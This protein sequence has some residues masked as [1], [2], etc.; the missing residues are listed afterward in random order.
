MPARVQ[1]LRQRAALFRQVAKIPTSGSAETDRILIALASQFECDADN[2][3][4]LL[5]VKSDR[6]ADAAT[7]P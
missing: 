3:E 1:E 7:S 4:R 5:S 6:A 2:R